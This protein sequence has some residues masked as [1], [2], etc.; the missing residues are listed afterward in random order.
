MKSDRKDW[1]KPD[2]SKKLAR[3][4]QQWFNSRSGQKTGEAPLFTTLELARLS[5]EKIYEQLKIEEPNILCICADN[6]KLGIPLGIPNT[7]DKLNQGIFE[8]K[9]HVDNSKYRLY[10]A[11]LDVIDR[12]PKGDREKI[13]KTFLQKGV[14]VSIATRDD[15]VNKDS[16]LDI[17]V[18]QLNQKKG[19]KK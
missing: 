18:E 7:R 1:K 2:S 19:P 13:E 3:E 4:K 6:K 16:L 10:G 15:C 17:I 11:T 14:K 5:L 12:M 8:D 9:P